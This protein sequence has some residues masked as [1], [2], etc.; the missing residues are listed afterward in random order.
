MPELPE[1]ECVRRTLA[2]RIVGRRVI[3]VEVRRAAVVRGKVTGRALLVGC[4][5][6]EP[7]RHGKHLALTTGGD[8]PCVGVHLGM[9]GSLC[10]EATEPAD[11]GD[12]HV[13]V[14]WKLDN[15]SM[16]S[17]RDPRR[18]GGVWTFTTQ[19]AMAAQRWSAL[20]PDALTITPKTLARRFGS[21]RGAIKAVLLDQTLIAGLGNI[22]ADEL[23]FACGL[24]PMMPACRLTTDDHAKLTT[25]MRRILRRAID[26]GGSSVRDYVDGHG[27]AGRY[28]R[29]HQVYGRA[30]LPCTV[31]GSTLAGNIIAG[32]TTVHC[33]RCQPLR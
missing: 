8:G 21:R 24:S 33:P 12:K 3:D 27:R 9:T 31:C 23:L 28:Q 22:Y 2:R 30:G 17:F 6:E 7:C 4:V 16:M 18:F 32:R 25:A 15:G 14:L 26:A 19:E 10:C 13:H 29:R 11:S 1:V 5:L 20:G